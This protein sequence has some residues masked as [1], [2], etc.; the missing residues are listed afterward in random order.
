VVQ[1]ILAGVIIGGVMAAA[2]VT[3]VWDRRR[4]KA[5]RK[6]D[7]FAAP[8]GEPIPGGWTGTG[9][10]FNSGITNGMGDAGGGDGI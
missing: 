9:G 8:H 10:T 4:R 7:E 2:V 1:L 6:E 3:A 5:L